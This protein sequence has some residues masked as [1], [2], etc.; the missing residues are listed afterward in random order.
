LRLPLDSQ[1]VRSA[2]RHPVLVF[3]TR[4]GGAEHLAAGCEIVRVAPADHDRPDPD[5]ML[6]ILAERGITRVLVEGGPQ[7]QSAFIAA[8]TVDLVYRYLAPRRLG[9][10]VAS[11]VGGLIAEIGAPE[12]TMALGPDLLERYRV[13]V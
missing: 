3:T 2:R 5:A 12:S 4:A 7:L 10:G 11:S 6:K 8:R 13:R 9:S 1:L